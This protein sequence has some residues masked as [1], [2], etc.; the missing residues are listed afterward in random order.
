[1]HWFQISNQNLLKFCTFEDIWKFICHKLMK[2]A[3][4]VLTFFEVGSYWWRSMSDIIYNSSERFF[5]NHSILYFLVAGKR[6][7]DP[8][9]EFW[10]FWSGIFRMILVR[11]SR[12]HIFESLFWRKHFSKKFG[13][14][15]H[16]NYFRFSNFGTF[17]K[18][19]AVSEKSPVDNLA[20]TK[21]NKTAKFIQTKMA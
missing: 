17:L 10:K 19:V 15:S 21:Q 16:R 20:K 7:P 5:Q 18:F 6:W 9:N 3:I 1:M 14:F 2:S 8:L 13:N 11:V 4:L 12:F